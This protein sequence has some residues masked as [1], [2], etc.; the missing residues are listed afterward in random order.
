MEIK[1]LSIHP[2]W[3]ICVKEVNL[4]SKFLDKCGFYNTVPAVG[5]IISRRGELVLDILFTTLES[6]QSREFWLCIERN[7][8][9]HIPSYQNQTFTDLLSSDV[10]TLCELNFY[11]YMKTERKNE[12]I[13]FAKITTNIKDIEKT[14]TILIEKIVE[15]R[16]KEED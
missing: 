14:H 5:R 12:K 2:S 13:L 16:V 11:G 15:E 4:I 9:L 8:V 10:R 6:I 1:V 3:G 7:F